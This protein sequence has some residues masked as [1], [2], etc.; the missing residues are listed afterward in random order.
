MEVSSKQSSAGSTVPRRFKK[1]TFV[2]VTGVDQRFL[3]IQIQLSKRWLQNTDN[4][5]SSKL[6]NC[7]CV[8]SLT[9]I[10][11][12]NSFKRGPTAAGGMGGLLG[13]AI[14]RQQ[15]PHPQPSTLFLFLLSAE[16]YHP[17]ASN[18]RRLPGNPDLRR[19]QVGSTHQQRHQKGQH[20]PRLHS[21]KP[22]PMPTGLPEHRLPGPRPTPSGVRRCRVGSLTEKGHRLDG[23]HSAQCS[24][25]HHRRLQVHDPRQCHQTPQE[26]W[27][28]ASARAPPATPPDSL[29]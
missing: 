15:M 11:R 19:S 5:L 14:Q 13:H 17:S 10:S 23:A 29:L 6:A 21:P 7:Q 24:T 2:P 12:D 18:L 22:T 16:Q 20:H 3:N 25:L 9:C 28:T 26:D 1:Q 4:R 8:Y 27:A